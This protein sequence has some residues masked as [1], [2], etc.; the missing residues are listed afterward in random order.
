MKQKSNKERENEATRGKKRY[1]ERIVEEQ[2]A[3]KDIKEYENQQDDG[4]PDRQYGL[5]PDRM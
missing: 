2:E 4:H 1:L 3:D 5:G